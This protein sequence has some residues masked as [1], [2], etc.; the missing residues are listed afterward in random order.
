MSKY[1][2]DKLHF[3]HE[4]EKKFDILSWKID[5][6]HIWPLIRISLGANLVKGHIARIEPEYKNKDSLKHTEL[7]QSDI[8]FLNHEASKIYENGRWFDSL[9]SPIVQTAKQNALSHISLEY[10]NNK[11]AALLPIDENS[12]FL[13]E[14]FDYTEPVDNFDVGEWNDFEDFLI[15]LETHLSFL[16]KPSIE[17]TKNKFSRIKSLAEKFTKILETTKP[18]IVMV[19]NTYNDYGFAMI[20]ACKKLKIKSVDIQHGF[21][22]DTH[23][24]YSNWNQIPQNGFELLPDYYWSWNKE[25]S[26]Q[27]NGW[28]EPYHTSVLAGHPLFN[29]YE[30]RNIKSRSNKSEALTILYTIQ[31]DPH[32]DKEKIKNLILSSPDSY[33]WI[34]RAHPSNNTNIDELKKFFSLTNRDVV[35]QTSHENLFSTIIGIDFHLTMSSSVAIEASTMNK[36]TIFLDKI[37]KEMYNKLF[38]TNWATY[39]QD[40]NSLEGAIEYLNSQNKISTPS[41]LK[42]L[43]MSQT[44]QRLRLI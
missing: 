7:K 31:P 4:I 9:I 36:A 24:A 41:Q 27:V 10:L 25:S 5:G 43:D 32:F 29:I 16:P 12:H 17:K 34:I 22:S 6:I 11:K 40:H 2:I 37:S 13:F 26:E 35:V 8:L 38:E 19:G 42:Q 1:H 20:L 28:G 23:F 21:F 39:M 15:F 30:K 14:E 3:L 18:K 33:K 44:F